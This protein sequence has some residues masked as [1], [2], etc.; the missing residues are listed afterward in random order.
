MLKKDAGDKSTPFFN[1]ED[2]FFNIYNRRSL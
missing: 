1:G 2:R